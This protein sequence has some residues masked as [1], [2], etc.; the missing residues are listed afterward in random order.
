MDPYICITCGMQYPP[1]EHPPAQCPICEDERQYVNP[2]G[3]RWTTLAEIRRHCENRIEK[4]AN[5]LHSIVTKP[6]FAIGQRAYLVQTSEGN[7]LWDCIALIDQDTVSALWAL[8]GVSAIAISHPHYYTTM[9]EWSK[10]FGGPP[11]F[12][13]EAD[14]QWVQRGSD[15][16]G[17][18][19]YWSGPAKELPGGLTLVHCGGHFEGGAVLH[20]KAGSAILPGDILQVCPDR[21]SFGFMYSYPNYIPL[22]PQSVR[23][24]VAAVQPYEFDSA[25][26]AFGN[27][28]A[29]GA[30]QAVTTS[31]NR[32]LRMIGAQELQVGR[33]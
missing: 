15:E 17:Y 18:I 1:S 16:K 12:L 21:K 14:R 25:Y 10:A 8:G 31:A 6:Q 24:I 19:E 7:L 23:N 13:H 9:I 33:L 30:K 4:V 32:Y 20:W 29:R 2:A 11:I 26:G 5:G 28:I 22:H 3:Q 27:V